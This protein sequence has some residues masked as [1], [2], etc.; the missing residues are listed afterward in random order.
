MRDS[1]VEN[2]QSYFKFKAGSMVWSPNYGWGEVEEEKYNK[3]FPILVKFYC[4]KDVK[5]TIEGK[6]SPYSILP[7]LFIDEISPENW[8]N[9]PAKL[10]PSTFVVNQDLEIKF[11]NSSAWILVKFA[12][13]KDGAVWV[14]DRNY[15][16]KSAEII[17]KVADFRLPIAQ[18][19][20]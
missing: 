11:S 19:G 12:M 2:K 9:P 4:G 5:Y 15:D 8:P 6:I 16:F 7:T 20:I 13:L 18:N 1:E 17:Y 10:D 14:F 3:I